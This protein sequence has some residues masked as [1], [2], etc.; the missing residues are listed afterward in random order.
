MDDDREDFGFTTTFDPLGIYLWRV[1]NNMQR[2]RRA[3]REASLLQIIPVKIKTAQD[4]TNHNPAKIPDD[5][6]RLSQP[7]R[8]DAID[9]DMHKCH[10]ITP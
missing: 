1:I 4:T 9:E 8:E 2:K 6:N 5:A 7:N 3:R 10:Q